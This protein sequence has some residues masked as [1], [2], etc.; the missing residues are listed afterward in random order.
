MSQITCPINYLTVDENQTRVIAGQV[1]LLLAIYFIIP[2]FIFPTILLL[3]F[4]FRLS[5]IKAYSPLFVASQWV[6]SSLK[7]TP[8]PVNSAPKR[9]A[10]Q[11]GLLFSVLLLSTTLFLPVVAY[12]IAGIFIAC[13]FLEVAFAFCLGCHVYHYLIKFRVLKS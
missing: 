3:D 11:I 4:G 5:G 1:T 9:F 13:A 8:I 12:W 10:A 6:I 7:I 2:H